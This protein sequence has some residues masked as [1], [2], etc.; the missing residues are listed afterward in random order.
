MPPFCVSPRIR[1][2]RGEVVANRS[3]T[4][5]AR[6]TRRESRPRRRVRR[7]APRNPIHEGTRPLGS[8]SPIAFGARRS[9]THVPPKPGTPRY[10]E[11]S[12]HGVDGTIPFRDAGVRAAK[13][14]HRQSDERAGRSA[15]G[16]LGRHQGHEHR[17]ATSS[18]D[19]NYSVRASRRAR[20]CSSGSSAPRRK[21][22]PLAP[23]SV[24]QRPAAT[25]RD[26]PRRGR[27]HGARA[28]PRA[29]RARHGAADGA[30]PATSRRRSVRISST[31]C[32]AASP[33]ST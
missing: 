22:A 8:I 21:S 14:S 6:I 23:Q 12:T 5:V 3:A 11:K 26:E 18:N 28:R 10:E 32:R 17:H 33:A 2:E 30:G 25:R 31:R 7:H 24:D 9:F 13:D 29:A 15:V 19:G 1:V 16:R 20:C 27:R 4:H